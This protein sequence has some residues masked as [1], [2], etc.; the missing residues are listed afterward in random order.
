MSSSDPDVNFFVS[1]YDLDPNTQS[2]CI[3]FVKKDR[4]DRRCR[5]PCY[6]NKQA[7]ELHSLITKSRPGPDLVIQIAEYIVANCC[8]KDGVRHGDLILSSP[9]LV[10][11]AGRWLEEILGHG[12]LEDLSK[13]LGS[14]SNPTTP[15]TSQADSPMPSSGNTS[16]SP[17]TSRA[18]KVETSL[19]SSLQSPSNSSKAS[20][21]NPI[22]LQLEASPASL[23]RISQKVNS[24]TAPPESGLLA[25]QGPHD[26]D[27]YAIRTAFE[28]WSSQVISSLS[29]EFHP[30]IKKPGPKDTVVS[31]FCL[32]LEKRDFETG[33]LYMFTR[34]HSPGFVKIGWT[35]KSVDNRLSIW[36]KCGYK[37]IKLFSVAGVP[38]AQRVET[39]THYELIKEWRRERICEGCSDVRKKNIRH[40]EWFE[41]SSEKATQVLKSWAELF[42][43]SNPYESNGLLKSEWRNIVNDMNLS[44]QAITSEGLI[45]RY[46]ATMLKDKA[47]AGKADIKEEALITEVVIATASGGLSKPVPLRDS[48]APTSSKSPVA[49]EKPKMDPG[50]FDSKCPAVK[51]AEPVQDDEGAS[52]PKGPD[53]WKVKKEEDII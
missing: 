47:L 26:L 22:S 21:V 36:S 29:A 40:Q 32:D 6:D 13:D 31:R 50:S 12:R 3:Y 34:K 1:F 4:P 27:F 30:A 44:K 7:T 49:E 25:L 10:P 20:S 52:K 39:L 17:V 28:Q 16:A 38:H 15:G 19:I 43:K 9:L 23:P 14:S 41:V 53:R 51:T 37:P 35:S 33:S 48:K 11:L 46:K 8:A 2:Q 24:N 45:E 5:Y 18:I 42:K